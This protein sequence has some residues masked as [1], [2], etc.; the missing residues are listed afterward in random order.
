M[1]EN[2]SLVMFIDEFQRL[3]EISQDYSIEAAIRQVA[4]ISKKITYIFSGS[5]RHLVEDMFFDSNRPFYKMCDTIYLGRIAN[6]HYIDYI[7]TAAHEQWNAYL[8]ENTI[9]RILEL[10]EN[11][12]YYVNYLCSKLW[13]YDLPSEA[14]V[15]ACWDKCA[16]EKSFAD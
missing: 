12:P 10:T 13:L 1:K 4:Q 11:H 9:I 5:N 3:K 2:L 15:D 7:Q 16:K 14:D 8:T 6:E